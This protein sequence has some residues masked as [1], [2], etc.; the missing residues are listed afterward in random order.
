MKLQNFFGNYSSGA[1]AIVD[2]NRLNYSDY[3]NSKFLDPY[4]IEIKKNVSRM[5]L[6]PRDLR[7]KNIMNI[8]TGREALAFLQFKPKYVYH[9]DI[10]R[11]QVGRMK[12]FIKKKKLG[13]LISSKQLDLSKNPLPKNKFDFIYLHGIIQHTD[14]PGKTLANLLYSLKTSGHMWFFFSRSGTLIRF[15]GEIQRRLTKFLNIDDFYAAMKIIENALFQDNKFSDSIMDSSFVPNQT[16]FTPD[17]YI[18]FLKENN[19]KIYGDSLLFKNIK[20][21]VDHIKFHEAVILFVKKMRPTKNIKK[22]LIENL[23][24]KKAVNQLDLKNYKNNKKI[25]EIIN[26]FNKLEPKLKKNPQAAFALVYFLE[27][28]KIRHYNEYLDGK[29]TPQKTGKFNKNSHSE[30]SNILSAILKL[31]KK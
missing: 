31:L 6:K 22:S 27:K 4:K 5:K 1:N 17:P 23:S 11:Y 30:I 20:Q 7:N 19:I 12:A 18:K 15:I 13:H 2:N 10:S 9:Y 16:L 26:T 24:P 25:R 8:G 14:H 21:K 28:L 29:K 3:F